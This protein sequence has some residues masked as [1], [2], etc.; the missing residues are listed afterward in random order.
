MT[1]AFV[2]AGCRER[3]HEPQPRQLAPQVQ[4]PVWREKGERACWLV[5]FRRCATPI[6]ADWPKG[7][8]M[9][10]PRKRMRL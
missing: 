10:L 1:S 7:P 5:V 4:V 2:R 8:L 9:F 3:K 6:C